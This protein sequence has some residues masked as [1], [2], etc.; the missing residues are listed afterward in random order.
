MDAQPTTHGSEFSDLTAVI[1]AGGLGTRLRSVVTDRPKVLAEIR[2]QPFLAYLL[3]QLAAGGSRSVVLCTGYRGDQIFRTFGEN[4]GPLQL[5]YS[6]ERT[7]LGTAGALRAAL[8]RFQSDP[9]LVLNGDSYCSLD[10]KKYWEWYCTRRTQVSMALARVPSCERYGRVVVDVDGCVT[11]FAEKKQGLGAGWIN[12]GIYFLGHELL[13]SIPE[14]KNISLEHDIF[15]RWVGHGLHGYVNQGR[16]LDIG[17]PDAFARAESFF[18]S[19]S[20]PEDRPFIILDRDG[21]IIEERE[22]LSRPEQ[23]MLI[24]GV[25]RA[26]RKFRQMGFGLVVTTNQSGVGRGL[27]DEAQLTRIHH[28][29]NELLAA[30]GVHLDGFYVCIHKPD[31]GCDCRKP[32]LGLLQKAAAELGFRPENSIVI[33]DKDC[34]IDMGRGAG[35]VTFLVRTGYGAQFE[36]TAAADFVVDDLVAASA[37]IQRLMSVEGTD[38]HGH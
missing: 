33:G 15:P 25:G 23:V 1:L 2:G 6:E 20:T 13:R 12:A 10:L 17:T 30:E 35:A 7:P 19:L 28:R 26:L 21:T 37:S 24:P 3:D 11:E 29:L 9:V 31:D 16:F 38:I 18:D 14:K 34:D 27:F 32:K 5:L 22:Y 4:Y 36:S 8:G